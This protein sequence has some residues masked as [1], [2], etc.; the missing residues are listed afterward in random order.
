M[1]A[2]ILGQKW[3]WPIFKPNYLRNSWVNFHEFG[4]ID[5]G[6]DEEDSKSESYFSDLSM[7]GVE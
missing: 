2:Q 4:V 3:A 1:A 6:I 7:L 5:E